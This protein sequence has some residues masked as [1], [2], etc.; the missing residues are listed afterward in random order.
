MTSPTTQPAD[1]GM[2]C[3]TVIAAAAAVDCTGD[4]L[5]TTLRMAG[6]TAS[7]ASQHAP[8]EPGLVIPDKPAHKLYRDVDATV[9]DMA[10]CAADD[11]RPWTGD[12]IAD[13]CGDVVYT[14]D[15]SDMIRLPIEDKGGMVRG[16]IHVIGW[17]EAE[18]DGEY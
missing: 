13:L 16:H 1:T 2:P 8:A 10:V 15:P 6:H 7:W 12:V 5:V 14:A 3:S 9:Q 17:R 18:E 4:E 11:G